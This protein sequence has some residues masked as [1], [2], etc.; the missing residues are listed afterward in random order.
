MASSVFSRISLAAAVAVMG[1]AVSVGLAAAELL[2]H[3]AIYSLSLGETQEPGQYLGVGG[4][5]QTTLEKTCD[6]WI[7]AEQVNMDV[8]TQSGDNLKQKLA[9]TGW[10]SLDGKRYRFAARSVTNGDDK[11]Y[12]GVAHVDSKKPGEAVYSQPNKITMKLPPGTQFYWG[13][14]AWLIKQARAGESRAEAV[15]FDGT[16]EE[17][18]QRAV[19]FIIP[20]VKQAAKNKLGPLLDRPGWTM[21]IAFYP[22]DSRAAEPQYE[23]QAVVL[24]NGVTPK[25]KMV[26]SSFTAIQTLEKIEALTSPKC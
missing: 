23:V 3:R 10:E 6:A 14:T 15:V 8:T 12:K 25:V 2:P 9:Y 17:G 1:L 7:T 13:L 21:R 18:P 22:L 19:A 24:D 20:L 4:A 5:V 26:F 16:D 11:R